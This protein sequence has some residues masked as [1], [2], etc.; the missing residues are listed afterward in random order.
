VSLLM[1]VVSASFHGLRKD[2]FP[3]PIR[4]RARLHRLLKNSFPDGFASCTTSIVPISSLYFSFLAAFS[5]RGFVHSTFSA[6]C[7]AVPKHVE[8]SF[9]L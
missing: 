7:A 1:I 4:I 9:G 6:A 8:F 5:R 3:Q 2:S